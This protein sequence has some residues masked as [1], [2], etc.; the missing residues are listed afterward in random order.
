MANNFRILSAAVSSLNASNIYSV[1]GYISSLRV[2][3]LTFGD[4]T[5]W[6]DFGAIRAVV[7]STL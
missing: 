3:V 7:V 4:G 2:D 5:G 6:T 1:Q